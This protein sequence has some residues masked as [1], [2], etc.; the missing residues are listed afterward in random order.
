MEQKHHTRKS[1][2]SV[3]PEYQMRNDKQEC[4]T[5]ILTKIITKKSQVNNAKW[6]CLT[7][8]PSRKFWIRIFYKM[9]KI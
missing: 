4:F 8:A 7:R 5:K 1:S 2:K 6:E 9:A 3:L